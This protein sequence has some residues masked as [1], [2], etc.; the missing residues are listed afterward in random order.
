MK[1]LLETSPLPIPTKPSNA[2]ELR[3]AID[4][5]RDLLQSEH[6]LDLRDE[7][8]REIARRDFL[9][10]VQYTKEDYRAN[11]HHELLAKKLDDFVEGK[12]KRLMVFMP[13]QHGKSQLTSRH[14]PAYLL[15]RN[16][17]LKIVGCSYSA[18]LAQS[19]NR[20]V[21]RIIDDEKF[22][23]L[24]PETYLNAS[25]VRPNSRDEIM[26]IHL[27]N[28]DMFETVGHR[29]YYK[30]VGVGGALTGSSVDVAIIDDPIKD[31]VEA[32]S[33]TYRAR[34]WDWFTSVL[35]TRVLNHT[36]IML[37]MTRW[38]EDDLAGRI[39]RN[40]NKKG[41]W[42]VLVL[43]A[44]RVS[45]S[46]DLDPRELGEALWPEQ[47]GLERL[48]EERQA[49]PRVFHAMYQQDPRPFEGGLV[50]KAP[51]IIKNETFEAVKRQSEFGLDW[52]FSSD[53]LALIE[54]RILHKEKQLYVRERVY[55]TG[56]TNTQLLKI[57]GSEG[58]IQ[59]ITNDA[60]KK[61]GRKVELVAAQNIPA[62]A[63]IVA[64]SS[65][66]KSI[67]E[68]HRGG[69]FGI[70][71]VKKYAGSVLHGIKKL[72]DYQ[73]FVTEESQNVLQELKE[74][75]WKEDKDGNPTEE[76][77][78]DANHAMDAIRYVVTFSAESAR[79]PASKI[80]VIW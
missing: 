58:L 64:D 29:G 59:E 16:P 35:M 12:I 48:E 68:I 24:F 78:D 19:F 62:N 51:T 5:M 6:P 47:K 73:W 30:S 34:L 80:D 69:Y 20:E 67:E 3:A 18:V 10:F 74:Y 33:M 25:S 11:W 37:T 52:G 2:A 13:P 54:V 31:A 44:I 77:E 71:G 49:Q 28:A 60:G 4:A 26:G 53:P 38:N 21:Q 27:R 40:L 8:K 45:E 43:P 41:Q 7:I 39:L 14:L 61:V 46:N 32:G 50:Y 63:R 1:N 79:R 76:P 56:I 9:S 72:Q 36:Q 22:Y 42:D 70:R 57:M 23:E 66:P 15:G 55:R 17:K 75:R 65:E